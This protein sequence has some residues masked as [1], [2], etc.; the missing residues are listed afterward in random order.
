MGQIRYRFHKELNDFIKPTLRNVEIIS[1]LNR[2]ASVKDIIETYGVPHTEVALILVNEISVDFSYI[3]QDGDT[4]CVYPSSEC[5][6]KKQLLKLRPEPPL[7]P[8]FVVD[9]NLGRLAHYLRLLGFDCLYHNNFSD[10]MVATISKEDDRIVLTRDRSLLQRKIITYGYFVRAT[11]PKIQVK[12]I[13]N[14]FNLF[15]LIAP[16]VRCTRCN[17]TLEKIE[18]LKIEHRLKPLT[19][20]YYNDFLICTTCSQIYWQGSHYTRAMQ[21]IDEFKADVKQ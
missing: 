6:E 1:E 7:T 14:R 16:F 21:L 11:I 10:D 19:K 13:L 18:K 2:K 4:I 9:A 20:Q 15:R 3:V 8:K 17:G 5:S 12:E